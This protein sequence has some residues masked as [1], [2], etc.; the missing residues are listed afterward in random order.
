MGQEKII[1]VKEGAA[2][3]ENKRSYVVEEY[4]SS[5]ALILNLY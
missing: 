2:Q 4:I 3:W 5:I 1:D